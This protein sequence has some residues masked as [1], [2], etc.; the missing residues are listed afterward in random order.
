MA[1]W[2]AA[3]PSALVATKSQVVLDS[4]GNFTA[5]DRSAD[6]RMA[7]QILAFIECITAISGSGTAVIVPIIS[8]SVS[9]TALLIVITLSVSGTA[10]FVFVIAVG[11]PVTRASVWLSR[12]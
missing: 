11:V 2:S 5:P 10:L 4:R 6:V 8:L 3:K 9:G 7:A 12:G 1:T